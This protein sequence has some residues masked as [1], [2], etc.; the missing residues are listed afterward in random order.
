M[1]DD[2]FCLTYFSLSVKLCVCAVCTVRCGAECFNYGFPQELDE[3]FLVISDTLPGEVAWKY[4]TD[5]KLRKILCERIDEGFCFPLNPK[6]ILADKG[7]KKVYDK[8]MASKNKDI[9]TSLE[10]SQT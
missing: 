2:T 10:I 4:V 6:W 7:W 9:Q 8:M 5:E 1:N 3:E